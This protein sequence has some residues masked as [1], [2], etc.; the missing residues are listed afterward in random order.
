MRRWQ[1]SS[2]IAVESLLVAE[3]PHVETELDGPRPFRLGFCV[4]RRD[5]KLSSPTRAAAHTVSGCF[6]IAADP[7]LRG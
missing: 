5:D 3:D 4:Q 7:S 1:E 6:G 2:N